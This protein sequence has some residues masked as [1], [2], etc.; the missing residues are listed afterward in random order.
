MAK[1][2]EVIDN[3]VEAQRAK[4]QA[5]FFVTLDDQVA[6]AVYVAYFRRKLGTGAQFREAANFEGIRVYRMQW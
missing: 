6:A 5:F 3:F 1:A 4:R 2:V